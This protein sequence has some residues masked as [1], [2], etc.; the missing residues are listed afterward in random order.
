[1]VAFCDPT[2]LGTPAEFRSHFAEPIQQGAYCPPVLPRPALPG[3][4]P[5]PPPLPGQPGRRAGG[6]PTGLL[7]ALGGVPRCPTALLCWAGVQASCQGLL[8]GLQL[9]AA[10]VGGGG[11]GQAEL[12]G[13]N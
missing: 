11:G 13:G 7:C 12:G 4:A 8:A 2:L 3:Q 1:M 5:M 6:L 10:Q 9:E